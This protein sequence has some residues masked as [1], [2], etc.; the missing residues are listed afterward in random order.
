M[1][2]DTPRQQDIE[3]SDLANYVCALKA[4]AVKKEIQIIFSTTEYHYDCEVGDAEWIPEFA[5][6]EQK[7][8]LGTAEREAGGDTEA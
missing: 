1:I 3:A 7:M 4:M 6:L 8:F 5:G 2:L